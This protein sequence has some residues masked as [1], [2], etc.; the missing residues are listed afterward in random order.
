MKLKN[1]KSIMSENLIQPTKIVKNKEKIYKRIRNMHKGATFLFGFL[2][3]VM[4]MLLQDKNVIPTTSF[5]TGTSDPSQ[6]LCLDN[7]FNPLWLIVAFVSLPAV[8][9]GFI[10]YLSVYHQKMVEEF[11]F[12]KKNNPIRWMEYSVSASLMLITISILCGVSDIFLWFLLGSSNCIGMLM[13]QLLEMLSSPKYKDVVEKNL[14]KYV[15]S[16]ATAMVFVPWVVPLY[17]FF[18]G[19][20]TPNAEVPSFVYVALLGIFLCFSSFGLN[21]FCYHILEKYDFHTTEYIYVL[22]SFTAK[23]ILAVDVYGGLALVKK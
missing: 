7:Q 14:I 1:M 19:L 17:Y 18:H 8:N 11:L 15:F 4:T 16:L 13:G 5:S 22:L 2:T 10:W 12:E 6:Q 20:A 21:S 23:T 9:H 3:M